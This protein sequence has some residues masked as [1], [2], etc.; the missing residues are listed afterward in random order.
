MVNNMVNDQRNKYKY[1]DR[2]LLLSP[3]LKKCY[4]IIYY[5]KDFIIFK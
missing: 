2:R 4:K 3:K 5:T 1:S